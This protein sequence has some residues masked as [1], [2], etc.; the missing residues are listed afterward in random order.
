MLLRLAI[1]LCRSHAIELPSLS[2]GANEDRIQLAIPRAW[3]AA[4][5]LARAD[6]ATEREDL[7]EVGLQLC[8]SDTE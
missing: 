8:V 6:L 4:H 2:L 3:M 1:L 5:A 7:A